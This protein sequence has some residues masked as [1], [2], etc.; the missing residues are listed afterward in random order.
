MKILKYLTLVLP[1]WMVAG[2]NDYLDITPPSQ[3][4][5]EKY[6]NEESQLASY[7]IGQYPKIL[8]S[9]SG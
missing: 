7:A 5:P 8:P 4:I 2:C 3:I 1:L 6:L 9:H